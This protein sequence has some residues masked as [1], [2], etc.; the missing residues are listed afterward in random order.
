MLLVEYEDIRMRLEEKTEGGGETSYTDMINLIIRI[1][2]HIFAEDEDV[3]GRFENS[4][5]GKV[6]EL[7]SERL[8]REGKAEGIAEGKAEGRAEGK[9][10]GK[11]EGEQRSRLLEQKMVSDG[12]IEDLVKSTQNVEYR[13]QL[14]AEYGIL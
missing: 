9:A 13:E 12:R 11:A 3:K 14:Y 6:L 4:M 10:E 1:A 7:E 2:D 8:L 5:G